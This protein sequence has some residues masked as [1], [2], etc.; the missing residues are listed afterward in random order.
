MKQEHS[1]IKCY[2]T[3]A[4]I[5]RPC[6]SYRSSLK[7]IIQGFVQEG[8]LTASLR[9]HQGQVNVVISSSKPLSACGHSH[10]V[11]G[12]FRQTGDQLWSWTRLDLSRVAHSVYFLFSPPLSHSLSNWLSQATDFTHINGNLVDVIVVSIV[13]G[14]TRIAYFQMWVNCITQF[15]STYYGK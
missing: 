9:S 5:D 12:H 15:I 14:F 3:V 4:I 2:R 13:V 8:S 10:C 6:A 1:K 11:V 7:V